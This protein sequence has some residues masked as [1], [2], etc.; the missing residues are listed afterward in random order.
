MERLD[1]FAAHAPNEPQD[2]F[3]PIMRD[4][5]KIPHNFTHSSWAFTD[6]EKLLASSCATRSDYIK[7]IN[8]ENYR[9]A[10][11]ATVYIFYLEDT[12]KWEEEFQKEYYLQWPWAWA[13]AVL[14]REALSEKF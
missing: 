10:R 4:K 5:P 3:T 6:N 12:K 11:Y 8:G 1:Y 9:L 14:D 13:K 2:W 7:H